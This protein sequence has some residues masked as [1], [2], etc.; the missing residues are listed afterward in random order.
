MARPPRAPRRNGSGGRRLPTGPKSALAG[1][2]RFPDP[3]G[4]I[5]ARRMLGGSTRHRVRHVPLSRPL[6]PAEPPAVVREAW[7]IENRPCWPL[8]VVPDEDLARAREGHALHNSALPRRLISNVSRA[9]PG[10]PSL[11][12]KR[13]RA[14]WDDDFLPEPLAHMG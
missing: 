5:E 14:G 8:D 10:K 3:V 4:R 13:E 2:H 9:H 12:P 1:R 6:A 7:T 11:D